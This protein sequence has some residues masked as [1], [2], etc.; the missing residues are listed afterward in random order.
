FGMS[1]LRTWDW[2]KVLSEYKRVCRLG[3]IIRITEPSIMAQYQN[4]P[5]LTQL[6][7]LALEAG[8]RSG[9]L[10]TPAADGVTSALVEVLCDSGIEQVQ[11]RVYTLSYQ[12]GD[13][14]G[15]RALYDDLSRFYKVGLAYFQKW[16]QVPDNYG[17]LVQQALDEISQPDFAVTSMVL[18][19]YGRN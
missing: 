1:W 18:T 17:D 9:R 11:S 16:T 13:V 12:A 6:N 3:G 5:A 7:R 8:Y 4:G 19:A 15:L 10:F 14:A 2:P